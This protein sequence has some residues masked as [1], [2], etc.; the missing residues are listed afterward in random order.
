MRFRFPS[1]TCPSE[2]DTLKGLVV[3]SGSV[4]S[5][6]SECVESEAILENDERDAYHREDIYQQK[7]R[8]TFVPF[9]SMLRTTTTNKPEDTV[10]A[11]DYNDIQLSGGI[12]DFESWVEVMTDL[13][14]IAAAIDAKCRARSLDLRRNFVYGGMVA[15][16]I[17]D[18]WDMV[19]QSEDKE[20]DILWMFV[21]L[22]IR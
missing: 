5:I 14:K 13:M 17:R 6:C 11:E 10:M 15:L 19:S 4:S 8:D 16:N 20:Q 12:G 9:H 21:Q 3:W 1:W 18:D 2:S 22:F 7:W